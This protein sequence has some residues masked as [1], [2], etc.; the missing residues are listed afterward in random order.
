MEYMSYA[1]AVGEA[2]M[3]DSYVFIPGENFD[4]HDDDDIAAV[5]L[6]GEADAM[7]R[8][9]REIESLR[10]ALSAPHANYP[11]E[12]GRLYDCEA[13]EARCHCDPRSPGSEPCIYCDAQD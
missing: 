9:S 6:V 8:E 2:P 4:P 12:P 7:R 1:Q 11:H 13:C 3:P 5:L 10:R